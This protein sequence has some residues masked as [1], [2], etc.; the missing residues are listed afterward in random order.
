MSILEKFGLYMSAVVMIL[1]L[2]LITFSQNGILDYQRLKK[3]SASLTDQIADVEKKNRQIEEEIKHLQSD[4]EYIRHLAK[5]EHEMA[6]KEELIFKTVS[7]AS[8]KTPTS[9]ES[10][11]K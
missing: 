9:E 1:M 5:H 11:S 3:K 2:F 6:E 8:E 7:P 10:Q 4:A